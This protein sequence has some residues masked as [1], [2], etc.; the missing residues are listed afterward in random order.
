M[1]VVSLVL[2]GG[3]KL[4]TASGDAI[5]LPTR[6]AQGLLA[7]L[8]TCLGDEQPRDKLT[9]LLWGDRSD[10]QARD[11]LR[12]ALTEIRKAV[13]SG[14]LRA[15]DG[16]VALD[17]RGIE[18]DTR[19][20]LRFAELGS[21]EALEQAAA[22][23]RGDFLEGF[24]VGEPP[25][26]EWLVSERERLRELALETFARLLALQ[27]K[28]G[29]IDRAIQTAVRLLALDP[30][31]E[32]VHRALM[33]L[34]ARRGRRGA[35]LRQYQLCVAALQRELGAEPE[36][37]T[38][39]L[40]RGIVRRQPDVAAVTSG[41][42]A[43]SAEAG[44]AM[45]AG[46]EGAD[47]DT[48]AAL[49]APVT[50]IPIAAPE[51]PVH[52]TPLVGRA[53]E[54]DRLRKLYEEAAGG[55]GNVVVISGEAGVGKSRLV[56]ELA[57]NA[58]PRGGHVLLGRCYQSTQIL[59][60][61][62]WVDAFRLGG[63]IGAAMLDGIGPVWRA[64]LARLLPEAAVPGL[65]AASE[66]PLRLFEAI[67]HLVQQVARTGPTV[68]ALEDCHWA[69]EMT[70]SL[71]AFVARR[72]GSWPV[73]LAVTVREDETGEAPLLQRTLAELREERVSHE[74]ALAPLARGDVTDLVRTVLGQ[75]VEPQRT[76][77][78][79]KRVWAVSEG[80]PFVILEALRAWSSEAS[81]GAESPLPL[82]DRVRGLVT[83]RL[84][85]LTETGRKL[86]AVAAVL[87]REFDFALLH[88]GAE[89]PEDDAA[90]GLEE[91][92]RRRILGGVGERFHFA[93]DRIR[94]V[95]Y[96]ELLPQRRRL[97][98]A[99]IVTALETVYAERLDEH[100]LTLAQHCQ[101]AALWGKARMYWRRAAAQAAERSALR[102]AAEC[103]EG[104][105]TALERL[106]GN[107]RD[108]VEESI[109]VRLDL[110]ATLFAGGGD[111]GRVGDLL[112]AGAALASEIG[113]EH[114]LARILIMQTHYHGIIAGELAPAEGCARQAL[115][116][117]QSLDAP[118]LMARAGSLLGRVQY[119]RAAY[120]EAIETLT[121]NIEFID[122][123]SADDDWT[124]VLPASL[125]SRLWLTF[126]LADVG[127]F[128]EAMTIADDAVERVDAQTH[129]YR[130]YHSYWARVA[131]HLERGDHERSA[132]G[133]KHMWA[134][135][136]ETDMQLL[137]D[138]LSGLAG[139]AHALAGRGNE[140]VTFLERALAGPTRD[141]FSGHRD[142]FY[143][144][145]AYLRVHRLDDARRH[146]ERALDL[147]RRCGQLGREACALRLLSSISLTLGDDAT[148]ESLGRQALQLG[149]DL[150]MRPLV[151]HC[152]AS[153]AVLYARSDKR[154]NAEAH[155][156]AA[157]VLYD[158]MQ[159]PYWQ[160][161]MERDLSPSTSTSA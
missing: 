136:R 95:A 48:V 53:T 76:D 35:A 9:A 135:L 2:F 47:H 4:R 111:V 59:P 114:R 123:R 10:A 90:S 12:H 34:Y 69:D 52:E 154:A 131:V 61:G 17:P 72:V 97:I 64:E 23:Y 128:A 110:R 139:R 36:L 104:A 105:L 45:P 50:E 28:V 58:L 56:D 148:A 33:R 39:E 25:F 87:G 118:G 134:A 57:M 54:V 144:A 129:P 140:A 38:T 55:H 13:G 5:H 160:R 7:Y 62:P 94:E 147:A 84:A 83:A 150:G 96:A 130:R 152:H 11:S 77:R 108:V 142:I 91:L 155:V 85:R 98:H 32:A 30:L 89:L 19:E 68:V 78:I 74:L 49:D 92:V 137:A 14:T 6:K 21:P 71:V 149:S 27:S 40:Y 3:F 157:T 18:V 24:A 16:G 99:R 31:Q 158:E 113:D 75:G 120:R 151:A 73:M 70:L 42:S 101:E 86:V 103:L 102:Q 141:A 41:S 8:A 133:L 100:A 106:P 143:L 43:A 51:L 159:M 122:A 156:T 115:A 112:A 88:V 145:D 161:E 65:P 1:G 79:E 121:R 67:G 119:G 26:E 125:G 138:S 15:Q 117:A 109:D 66:N 146:A 124:L 126:A 60:F 82:P 132:E 29:Q 37:E 116:I 107:R 46:A 93:H 20:L 153:L 63:V 81:A 22:L 80:N 44:Y 127:R